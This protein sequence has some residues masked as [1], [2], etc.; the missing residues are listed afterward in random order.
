LRVHVDLRDPIA[1]N[2]HPPQR[3][4]VLVPPSALDNYFAGLNPVLKTLPGLLSAWFV[5][6][7]RV[8]AFDPHPLTP[9]SQRVTV[10]GYTPLACERGHRND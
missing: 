3:A 10:N 5:H 4:A 7:W 8:H 6:L 9:T 2:V 1:V